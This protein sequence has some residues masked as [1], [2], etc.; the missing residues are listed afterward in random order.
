[1]ELTN[2]NEILEFIR[3][4]DYEN[5]IMGLIEIEPIFF[6]HSR[7]TFFNK[8]QK[9]WLDITGSI[10]ELFGDIKLYPYHSLID[11]F[12]KYNFRNVSLRIFIREEDMYV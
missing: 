6:K 2:K 10:S 1:M 3:K 12:T 7:I 5:V 11:L 9:I 4:N 8:E